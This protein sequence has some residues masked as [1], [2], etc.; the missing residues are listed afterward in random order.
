MTTCQC[1]TPKKF[2]TGEGVPIC[3]GCGERLTAP[4][5]AQVLAALTELSQQQ[6][7]MRVRLEEIAQQISVGEMLTADELGKRL[8]LSRRFVYDHKIELG[9]VQIAGR[10]RFDPRRAITYMAPKPFKGG[11]K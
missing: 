3:N 2:V 8:S 7:E 9:G 1:N 10:W 5:M 4:T 11:S 6:F